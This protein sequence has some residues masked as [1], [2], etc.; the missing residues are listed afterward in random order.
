[1]A[2]LT[3]TYKQYKADTRL[4][5]SWLATT[6]KANGWSEPGP[7]D[8]CVP[9]PNTQSDPLGDGENQSSRRKK[10]KKKKGNAANAGG[11]MIASVGNTLTNYTVAISDFVPMAKLVA[12]RK[13][14]LPSSIAKILERVIRLREAFAQLLQQQGVVKAEQVTAKKHSHFVDILKQVRDILGGANRNDASTDRGA[15]SSSRQCLSTAFA[16][17]HLYEPSQAFLDA[18]DVAL[19]APEYDIAEDEACL[20]E[21]AQVAFAALLQ[22]VLHL[23]EEVN[24]LW[25]LKYLQGTFHLAA[26][27]VATNTAIDLARKMEE[28]ATPILDRFGG[29]AKFLVDHYHTAASAEGLDPNHRAADGDGINTDA[30]DISK[31]TMYEAYHLLDI[32]RK[33]CPED[34]EMPP[35]YNGQ[36][37]GWCHL[38][39]V[40][41][42]H[43]TREKYDRD[44]AGFSE[45]VSETAILARKLQWSNVQDEFTRGVRLIMADPSWPIPFWVIFAAQLF[46]DNL[47]I[48]GGQFQCVYAGLTNIGRWITCRSEAAL[49]DIAGKPRPSGWPTRKDSALRRLQQDAH[50]FETDVISRWKRRIMPSIDRPE[51]ILMKCNA[52]FAGVWAHHLLTLYHTTAI[53]YVNAWGAVFA[54]NQLNNAVMRL[55]WMTARGHPKPMWTD[56]LI[57]EHMQDRHRFWVGPMP[58]DIKDFWKQWCLC[59]GVSLSE[60]VASGGAVPVAGTSNS[61]R[62]G[63]AQL[64]PV[65]LLFRGRLGNDTAGHARVN[66]TLED[67]RK[68]VGEGEWIMTDP[69]PGNVFEMVHQY[70]RASSRPFREASSGNTRRQRLLPGREDHL[71][72]SP[73]GLV[74]TLATTLHA[75]MAELHFDYLYLHTKCWMILRDFKRIMDHLFRQVCEGRPDYIESEAQLPQLVGII[76]RAAAG[77]APGLG[78]GDRLELLDAAREGLRWLLGSGM[79]QAVVGEMGRLGIPV[80]LEFQSE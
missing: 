78:Q 6:A 22:D 13:S 39:E 33:D 66:M 64:A 51:S 57:M 25:G 29:V 56:M 14:A 30:Y 38:D 37:Y 67:V 3:N 42:S 54:M 15:S 48:L 9:P 34:P 44:C 52:V 5:A 20:E 21:D 28:E 59:Q 26:V 63:L 31:R 79:N 71:T 61:T 80:E 40:H 60:F 23:R 43:S 18:P 35:L 49:D 53:A 69:S 50:F 8:S 36:P 72:L 46:I 10:K 76:F 24:K 65:S 1:M 7:S 47:E 12:K 68:I 70:E 32:F 11:P 2:R 77:L 62:R 74:K 73:A 17:L 16:A 41:K 58:R 55:M 45:I 27:A 75:E 19:P 4:F